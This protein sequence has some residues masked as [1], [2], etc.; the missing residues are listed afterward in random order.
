MPYYFTIHIKKMHLCSG[1]VCFF[2]EQ[3]EAPQVNELYKIITHFAG[4]H[5]ALTE[6]SVFKC[7]RHF[8][9]FTDPSLYKYLETYLEAYRVQRHSF[10]CSFSEEEIT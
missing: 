2:S 8:N 3:P 7:I 10:Y 6:T 5:L 9:Q 4:I 1:F